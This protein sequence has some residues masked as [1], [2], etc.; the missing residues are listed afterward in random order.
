[1]SW[2]QSGH[3]IVTIFHLVGVSVSIRQLR[4]H[5]SGYDLR[6]LRRNWRLLTILTDWTSIIRSPLT[7]CFPLFLP[8]LTSLI[9]FILWLKFF[10]R[11][12]AGWGHRGQG[13]AL[14]EFHS[15]TLFQFQYINLLYIHITYVCI[16]YIHIT[17]VCNIHITYVYNI[18]TLHVC[19]TYIHITYVCNMH[20]YYI[21]V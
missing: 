13:L 16:T 5:G 11:Q 6:P 18:C 4:R 17:Y 14:F 12:K 15:I 7:V 9:K 1:M 2:L 19:I 21:C 10:Y 20:T 8:F 3:H